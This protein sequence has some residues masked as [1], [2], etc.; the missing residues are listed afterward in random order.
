L[1]ETKIRSL[2]CEFL[3]ARDTE[4]LLGIPTLQSLNGFGIAALKELQQHVA[5]NS[6]RKP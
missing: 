5:Q 6:A 3:P 4:L 1:I 2:Q